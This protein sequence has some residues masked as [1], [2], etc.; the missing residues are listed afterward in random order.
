ML[1]F[2]NVG[3]EKKKLRKKLKKVLTNRENAI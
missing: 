2:I 1:I 3:T